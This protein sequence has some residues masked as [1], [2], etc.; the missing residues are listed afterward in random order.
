[1]PATDANSKAQTVGDYIVAQLHAGVDP[2]SAALS[3]GITP[4]E[5]G[6]WIRQGS[7]VQARLN[8]GANWDTDF[9]P[10]DQDACLFAAAARRAHGQHVA[11][12]IIHA[13]QLARGGLVKRNTRRKR[14]RNDT[15]EMAIVEELIT[16]ETMLPDGDMLRWKI[17]ALVPDVYGKR[18]NLDITLHDDTDTDVVA[19]LVAERIAT[20]IDQFA[21]VIELP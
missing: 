21:P 12:L 3:A 16:E 6:A 8:N 1:M 17:A 9:T 14:A 5:Y 19:T 2:P 18:S 13:E 10:E 15:G 7:L 4:S 11:T 20:V